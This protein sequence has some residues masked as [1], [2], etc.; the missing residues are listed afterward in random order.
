MVLITLNEAHHL[1]A[2]LGNLQGWASEVFVVDSYSRDQTV[3]VALR[4]GVH[5]VQRSFRGFG[6]QWNFALSELPITAPWTM[7]MDPDERLS[8]ELKRNLLQAMVRQQADA[9][10]VDRRLWLM[11]TP[12]P[13]RQRI[14]RVW[15]SGSCRFSDT[16]VNEQ[17]LVSGVA[18]HVQGEMEHHDSPDLEHWL[19]KQN[20][21]TTAE[22]IILY[23]KAPLAVEPRLLGSV[24]QR[25]MWL[26]ANFHRVP[27]RY[28]LL[29]L[30]YLLVE[31][32]WRAGWVGMVWARLRAD[33]MRF[34]DYKAREIAMTGSVP[35]PRLYGSGDPDPRVAQH[36]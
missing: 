24:L 14:L 28:A 10:S 30:Y 35:H 23:T 1:S 4:F 5:V 33:V 27:G 18:H 25:R 15:R 29:F 36:G 16:M 20:R 22:A 26:K 2:V 19:E 21:Y 11:R 6:D 13:I 34:R 7:K 31:G 3:D 12:L 32:A 8:P 9:F 17:P